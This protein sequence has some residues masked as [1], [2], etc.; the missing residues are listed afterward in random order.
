M[1]D[2]IAKLTA[3]SALPMGIATIA[4]RDHDWISC[5]TQFVQRNNHVV[6]ESVFRVYINGAHI[7]TTPHLE[8]AVS[9][10]EN[11]TLVQE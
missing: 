2:W 11:P 1:T 6:G 8:V 4:S 5:T 9:R 3:P 7:C 10:F